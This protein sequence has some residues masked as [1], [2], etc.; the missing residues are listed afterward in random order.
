MASIA[1]L[2]AWENYDHRY[3]SSKSRDFC[4][5]HQPPERGLKNPSREGWANFGGIARLRSER[6]LIA[7]DSRANPTHVSHTV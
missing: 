3:R 4:F 6:A 1:N 5:E 7:G 2:S